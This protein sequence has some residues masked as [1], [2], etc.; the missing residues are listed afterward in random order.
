MSISFA[1]I[2]QSQGPVGDD[3]VQIIVA[4]SALIIAVADGA[5]GIRGS[6]QAAEFV[7]NGVATLVDRRMPLNRADTWTDFLSETDRCIRQ[8]ES[9]G[10]T[11]GLVL[12]ITER[13]LCGASVGDSEAWLVTPDRF[14]HLTIGQSNRPLLGSGQARPVGFYRQ[15]VAATVVVGTDGLFRFVPAWRVS[16]V[17]TTHGADDACRT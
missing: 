11:T 9:W 1:S 10:E 3:R 6:F 8:R 13:W 5:G 15:H 16:E 7:V 4:G 2:M 17:V 12:A 14:H